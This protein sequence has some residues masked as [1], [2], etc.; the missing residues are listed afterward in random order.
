MQS[1]HLSPP[2]PLFL[3]NPTPVINIL[4]SQLTTLHLNS[5]R[6]ASVQ[7]HNVDSRD[8]VAAL[9]TCKNLSSVT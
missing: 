1:L 4:W 7:S 5:S 2:W 3:F 9:R 8:L 6:I